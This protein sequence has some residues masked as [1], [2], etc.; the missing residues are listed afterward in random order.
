MP[1]VITTSVCAIGDEG[2]QHALLEAVCTT[3]AVKPA[4]WL[5]A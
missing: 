5:E 4:G 1:A 2:E 3:L